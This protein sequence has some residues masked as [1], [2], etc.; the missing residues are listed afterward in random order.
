MSKR[1]VKLCEKFIAARDTEEGA[2]YGVAYDLA[3]G[4]MLLAHPPELLLALWECYE[5]LRI[6]VENTNGEYIPAA[7]RVEE[8]VKKGFGSE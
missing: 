6:E 3:R 4:Q 1:H 2:G 7:K 5:T 8:L